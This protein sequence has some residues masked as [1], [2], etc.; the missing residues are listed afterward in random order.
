MN[1]G[2]NGVRDMR[3]TKLSTL[4]ARPYQ[5]L[6]IDAYPPRF[7]GPASLARRKINPWT[8]DARSGIGR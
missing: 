2:D 5:P 8:A 4:F 6:E 7:A 1:V 3:R